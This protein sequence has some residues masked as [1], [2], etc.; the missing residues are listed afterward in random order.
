MIR[1]LLILC[2]LASAVTRT[3]QD[4]ID[5][6]GRK[7]DITH[8]YDLYKRAD[9]VTPNDYGGLSAAL[10]NIGSIPRTLLISDT[11]TLTADVTIPANVALWVTPGGYFRGSHILTVRGS[12]Q[13]GY[14]KWIDSTITMS[15]GLLDFAVPQ[16]FGA[17]GDGASN[18]SGPIA[19]SMVASGVVYFPQAD[20]MTSGPI[21]VRAGRTLYGESN[22]PLKGGPTI[23][24]AAG[25]YSS[26]FIT[27]TTS[28]SFQGITVKHFTL[29]GGNS[30][31]WNNVKNKWAITSHYPKTSIENI[32]V[33][34][35][36]Y[37][38]GNGIRLHNDG[39]AGNGGSM[40]CWSSNIRDVRFYGTG[41]DT[42]PQDTTHYGLDMAINGGHVT[43]SDCVFSKTN[44]GVWLRR[45][46]DIAF[47]Q[48]DT[49]G[50]RAGAVSNYP[51]PPTAAAVVI[52]EANTSGWVKGCTYQGY[53]EGVGRGFLVQNTEGLL[54]HG[55]YINTVRAYN[56]TG[57]NDGLI[58]LASTATGVTVQNTS[59]ESQYTQM[60]MMHS[61]TKPF[62]SMGNKLFR[63]TTNPYNH[64][65]PFYGNG[66]YSTG[67]QPI[68]INDLTLTLDSSSAFKVV[69]DIRASGNTAKVTAVAHGRAT[70][71]WCWLKGTG[72]VSI[73][74]RLRQVTVVN[75]DTLTL[76]GSL[77]SGAWTGPDTIWFPTSTAVAIQ[78]GVGRVDI[79][80][81]LQLSG[82]VLKNAVSGNESTG[83]GSAALGANSPAVTLTA[84]FKWLKM[85]L[86][87]GSVGYTPV[88]K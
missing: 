25:D 13:A 69:T 8:L 29:V 84:P 81:T 14:F 10:L 2:S 82:G 15:I 36:S 28:A 72:G 78:T 54:I 77:F 57:V 7:G 22:G 11:V 32:H 6:V 39:S 35:Q 70:G 65:D 34:A 49:E 40:G 46:E 63:N 59:L 48:V 85:I 17:K 52:G 41:N 80:D 45:G 58:Y 88:W 18:D 56:K 61:E 87:D 47:D 19:R 44:V 83:A 4:L 68:R 1:L 75:A 20:Y 31:T 73:G 12:I 66:V 50:S 3:H 38:W 71:D 26:F 86:S 24:H 51:L 42:T 67:A 60:S 16:W 23:R 9:W 5:L 21:T 33:D 27:D 64:P 37:F 55:S 30:G 43:V 76:D 74:G 62:I 53:L 79:G